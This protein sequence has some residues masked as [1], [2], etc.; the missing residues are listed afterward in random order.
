MSLLGVPSYSDHR[1]VTSKLPLLGLL[2]LHCEGQE[3]KTRAKQRAACS[4][5]LTCTGGI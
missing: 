2:C 1:G 5:C 3:D 4:V